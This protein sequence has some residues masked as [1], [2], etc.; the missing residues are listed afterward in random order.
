MIKTLSVQN[1]LSAGAYGSE[2]FMTEVDLTQDSARVR[3]N[4]PLD[5]R[6]ATDKENRQMLSDPKNPRWRWPAGGA[7]AVLHF[8]DSTV[9]P[10]SVSDL[11]HS[12]MPGHLKAATGI[13]GSTEE[14][15]RPRRLMREAFEAIAVMTPMGLVVPSFGEPELDALAFGTLPALTNLIDR[16]AELPD[17]FR[18]GF[19]NIVSARLL[20]LKGEREIV[21]CVNGEEHTQTRALVVLDEETRGIDLMHAY[22]LDLRS[23][24]LDEASFL[25]TEE[26]EGKALNA[27]VALLEL[28]ANLRP[29]RILRSYKSGRQVEGT[30]DLAKMSTV[31]RETLA[32]L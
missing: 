10:L 15:V 16:E 9:T 27:E 29:K 26:A 2:L 12:V 18:S 24:L 32:A 31:L 11:T 28:D 21:V 6:I 14:W 23:T 17:I 20:S 13:S 22:E 30:A 5:A 8:S 4:I 7:I 3:V 1:L 25:H 19:F